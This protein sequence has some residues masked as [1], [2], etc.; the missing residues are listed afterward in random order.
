MFLQGCAIKGKRKID[1]VRN[2]K[3]C[4]GRWDEGEYVS[5]ERKKC[6]CEMSVMSRVSRCAWDVYGDQLKYYERGWWR[7]EVLAM[8][9]RGD[10]RV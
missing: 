9:W 1:E 6:P 4:R 8:Q 2:R 7:M 5:V 10:G 3:G